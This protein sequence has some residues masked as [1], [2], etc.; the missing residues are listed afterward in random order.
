MHTLHSQKKIEIFEKQMDFLLQLQRSLEASW[1]L[2]H[3]DSTFNL[4]VRD[5][6]I[7]LLILLAVCVLWQL[8]AL[9]LLGPIV[10]ME[11][12]VLAFPFNVAQSL[13]LRTPRFWDP[14]S[15]EPK[16]TLLTERFAELK[17]ET[18]QV[19]NSAKLPL[20]ADVSVQQRGIA[21][22]QPWRVF[23]FFAYGHVNME[24]CRKA[25]VLSGLCMQIPSV[26][27]AMLSS[28]DEGAEIP[29]H[30]GYFKSILRVH[31]PLVIDVEDTQGHRFIEVGGERHSWR[32][33][34]LVAFDDTFPH[35]VSNRVP[36]RRVV[37]FLD[38]ERPFQTRVSQ[39]LS[40]ALLALMRAS[41]SVREHAAL[42]E[43]TKE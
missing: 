9:P 14:L 17:A 16:L 20:F 37:L 38:V 35:R 41:P 15:L 21:S 19:L 2:P 5:L 28:M 27:L 8:R 22:K 25:P 24:N 40:K 4:S 36:G 39:L 42:Q 43:K 34:Q 10:W 30:C 7:T 6:V 3:K 18:L 32:E 33:G 26:R 29:M 11:P 31:L 23:P 12:A 1:P 13:L